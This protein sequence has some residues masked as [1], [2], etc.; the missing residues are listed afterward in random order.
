[1][2]VVPAIAV[3]TKRETTPAIKV[4][5]GHPVASLKRIVIPPII[6]NKRPININPI[7]RLSLSPIF[8]CIYVYVEI[9]KIYNIDHI[10]ILYLIYFKNIL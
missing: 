10:F 3:P 6:A 1:M 5:N 9:I 4:H 8:Q 7:I 2:E